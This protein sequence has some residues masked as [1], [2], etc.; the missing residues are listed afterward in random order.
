MNL[1]KETQIVLKDLK[2]KKWLTINLL[3]ILLAIFFFGVGYLVLQSFNIHTS[4]IY[5][6]ILYQIMSITSFAFFYHLYHR[7]LQKTHSVTYNL[8]NLF[9]I[10]FTFFLTI[11][12]GTQT[13]ILFIAFN[14]VT[15]PLLMILCVVLSSILF[16]ISIVFTIF[17]VELEHYTK[18]FNTFITLIIFQI[19]WMRFVP[20]SALWVFVISSFLTYLTWFLIYQ[21]KPILDMNNP[22]KISKDRVYLTTGIILFFSFITFHEHYTS[23]FYDQIQIQPEL[24]TSLVHT[25]H[26]VY[27]QS[28]T[29]NY[30]TY[31]TDENYTYI[32][33]D[34]ALFVIK[35]ERIMDKFDLPEDY[36]LLASNSHFL[37]A[38]LTEYVQ[39]D[40][41]E[42]PYHYD[43]Y[44]LDS[45]L[46]FRK[47][48]SLQM[49]YEI[50]GYTSY[51]DIDYYI[52]ASNAFI[53]EGET[54]IE[55]IFYYSI[56]NDF[57]PR[58][59]P[60][61]TDG[62]LGGLGL[63]LEGNTII[64]PSTH[65]S[66]SI[67]WIEQ[68]GDE[69]LMSLSWG[70]YRGGYFIINANSYEPISAFGNSHYN[71]SYLR[72]NDYQFVMRYGNLKIY[73]QDG[74]L[75]EDIRFNTRGM[76]IT[77]QKIYMTSDTYSEDYEIISYNIYSL[78]LQ[79]PIIYTISN[80]KLPSSI[81]FSL[82]LCFLYLIID[83][84]KLNR[85][86]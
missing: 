37:I 38:H 20:L 40:G 81:L 5:G 41:E 28:N 6:W 80:E 23:Y 58:I 13:I 16:V 82:S 7:E 48:K 29:Y 9:L 26:I 4:F 76:F 8:K 85:I 79:Q 27:E 22:I 78:N 64:L 12:F 24:N 15:I 60:V 86:E 84:R 47:T 50:Y 63:V 61:M 54:H 52:A 45:E 31:A 19:I 35:D 51:N 1:Y 43:F 46:W 14:E 25:H 68:I 30:D 66:S 18:H 59:E 55:T 42:Y 34:R 75:Y 70:S 72:T 83:R 36:Q 39:D 11:W 73:D 21:V 3:G 49:P 74:K 10:D 62:N 2:P 33:L 57:T 77:D 69:L 67:S 53:F 17:L 32:Q 44:E 56:I 71:Y 65:Y